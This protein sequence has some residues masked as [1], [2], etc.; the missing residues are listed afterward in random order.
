MER[1]E[2]EGEP[3]LWRDEREGGQVEEVA[4]LRGKGER[5]GSWGEGG[6]AL[7]GRLGGKN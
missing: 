7:G 1:E 6:G 4:C 3:T 2:F 5:E